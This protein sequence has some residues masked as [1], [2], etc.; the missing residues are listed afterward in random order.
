TYFTFELAQLLA[1]TR[2]ARVEPFRGRRD[3][4]PVVHD[5]EQVLEL[6]EGHRPLPSIRS[7]R[8]SRPNFSRGGFQVLQLQ[9]SSGHARNGMPPIVSAATH[10]TFLVF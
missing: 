9:R 1:D 8:K 5:A 10:R 4:Q 6:L 7:K 3:V 2:L